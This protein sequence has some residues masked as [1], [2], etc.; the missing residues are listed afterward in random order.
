MKCCNKNKTHLYC[1]R[2]CQWK[3]WSKF[4]SGKNSPEYNH[5]KSLDERLKDRKYI[6]YY[7]WRKQVYERDNYTCQ[8]CGER[9]GK[10]NAHHI[11]SWRKHADLRFTISNGITLCEKCHKKKHKKGRIE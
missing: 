3:G 2:E 7:E 4:Y 5:E 1:S 11:K 8:E 6:E 9:G 10:L